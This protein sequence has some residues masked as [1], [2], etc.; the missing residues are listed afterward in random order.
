MNPRKST[1]TAKSPLAKKRARIID[2]IRKRV[3][4]AAADDIVR[5]QGTELKLTSVKTR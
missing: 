5:Q 4:G 1:A 2:K 3:A